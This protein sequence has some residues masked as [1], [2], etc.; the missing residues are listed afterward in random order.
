M[1]R[2]RLSLFVLAFT[3]AV[4]WL[5]GLSPTTHATPNTP[6]G[7][8]PAD[9]AAIQSFLPS[10]YLKASNTGADDQFGWAVAVDGDTVVVGAFSED[11]NA[12]G[13]NG[14]QADNSAL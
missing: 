4:L 11:S 3:A 6:D 7:L 2:N 9:W 14:D 5:G 12:T 8:T 13:V 1:K 10:D